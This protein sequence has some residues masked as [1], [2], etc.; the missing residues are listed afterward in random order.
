MPVDLDEM[1][2]ALRV[3]A[4]ALPL[5][6]PQQVRRLGRRHRLVKVAATFVVTCAAIV[7]ATAFAAPLGQHPLPWG[8]GPSGTGARLTFDAH[9]SGVNGL[10]YSPD[11]RLLV[12][13]GNDGTVRLWDAQT[14]GPAATLT[15]PGP[16]AV[17][18]QV[19]FS[20]DSATVAASDASGTIRLW[21]P[22]TAAIIRTLAADR[23]GPVTDIAFS[24]DGRTLAAASQDG[25]VRLWPVADGQPTI[26]RSPNVRIIQFALSPDGRY[27]VTGGQRVDQEDN[28]NTIGIWDT[29]TL[30]S[31]Q[32]LAALSIPLLSVAFSPDGRTFAAGGD[33][34]RVWLWEKDT[35][36]PR[37]ELVTSTSDRW[38]MV[39][40]LAF[41][42]D[43]RWLAT[44]GFDQTTKLWD[45][46]TGS[47]VA[48]FVGPA[49]G[50]S[51]LAFSPDGRTLAGSSGDGKVR[52]W[53]TP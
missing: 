5:N 45:A 51:S 43:G 30:A 7:A 50:L 20:P 35:A 36:T 22:A 14:G 34:G 21:D 41:S 28:Q 13:A 40:D 53:D 1:F 23:S 8:D 49:E 9:A 2:Q 25:P 44:A 3:D 32:T 6:P 18:I 4:D 52:L 16:P 31:V 11:G 12:T 47:L 26:I 29:E 46:A 38:K 19:A 39:S 17:V 48:T 33:E 42:P 24:P 37:R 15:P 10:A 27:I